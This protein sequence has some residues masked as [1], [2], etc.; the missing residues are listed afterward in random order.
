M[1]LPKPAVLFGFGAT[2]AVLCLLDVGTKASRVA[3]PS[4]SIGLVV[5]WVVCGLALHL[6]GREGPA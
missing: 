1:R 2:G 3:R 4:T 6:L 5:A